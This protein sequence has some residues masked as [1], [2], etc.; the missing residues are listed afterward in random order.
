MKGNFIMLQKDDLKEAIAEVL[1]TM[2]GKNL[3]AEQKSKDDA[4]YLTR[5][6]LCARLHITYT[7]LWRMEKRGEIHVH[8]I[9]RRNLYSKEEVDALITQ[10][11]SMS[12]T[13]I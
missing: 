11:S 12:N 10:G 3:L 2:V 9:G 8:K 6:E 4:E 13:N 5:D 1:E 7:T